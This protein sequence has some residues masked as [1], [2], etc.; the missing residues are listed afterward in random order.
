MGS[1][2]D[3]TQPTLVGKARRNA[4]QKRY[5]AAALLDGMCTG[6]FKHKP[7]EGLRRCQSCKDSYIKENHKFH[8]RL[9]DECFSAYGGY[10]CACCGELEKEFLTLDHKNDDGAEHRRELRSGKG[11]GAG[12]LVYLDLRK[13]GY[14]D[15]YQ[16]LCM[17]CNWGRRKTGTCPHKRVP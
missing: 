8:L 16:V 1:L 12:W 2:Q 7:I 13:K 4:K 17:N 14:P 6:C 11:R 10:V 9:K 5:R 3:N 15:G